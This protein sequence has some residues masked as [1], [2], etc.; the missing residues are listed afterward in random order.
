M[1]CNRGHR[2]PGG[3]QPLNGSRRYSRQTG[4]ATQL[5][6]TMAGLPAVKRA[7][8]L[9]R[10]QA[11]IDDGDRLVLCGRRTLHAQKACSARIVS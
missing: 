8:T 6:L 10:S 11:G 2:T 4:S 7:M 9:L 5:S 1:T 3:Q